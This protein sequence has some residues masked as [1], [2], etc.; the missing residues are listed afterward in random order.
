MCVNFICARWGGV[1]IT[2]PASQRKEFF[3]EENLDVEKIE[4]LKTTT[5]PTTVATVENQTMFS[6]RVIVVDQ[7]AFAVFRIGGFIPS[8]HHYQ[9][10]LIMDA[11]LCY[12]A[13][14]GFV[15]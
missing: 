2:A 3:R 13:G 10:S 4:V 8:C 1:Y 14:P 5:T 7:L 9:L 12:Q 11:A 15:M 6:S